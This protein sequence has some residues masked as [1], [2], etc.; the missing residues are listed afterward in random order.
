MQAVQSA[1]SV[2]PSMLVS[3]TYDSKLNLAVLKFYDPKSKRL[4]LW[5][6]NTG[7]KPYCYA[8]LSP[9][10]LGFLHDRD[11]VLDIRT[12][13]L[14]DLARD[15]SVDMS[16][17]TVADPLAIGGT[18]SDKSIRN[19]IETWESDIKYYE[20]YLYDK[21][22]VVGRYYRVENGNIT[23]HNMEI[24]DEVKLALKSLLWDKV[25]SRSM[26]DAEGF[27]EFISEWADLLNQPIPRIRRLAVDIEVE[28]EKD[29]IPDPKIAEKKITA[30][31][32]KGSDDFD[33][34]FVLRT[35]GT[36]E[37]TNDLADTVRVVFYDDEKEMIRDAFEVI[38]SFP[39]VITYN[40][41][42]FDL[43][44]LYHRAKRLGIGDEQNPV[45]MMRNSA[46]LKDGVHLDLYRTLSNRSFQ[47]YAFSQA[48]TDF[49]LNSVS[50]ALLGKEKIDYGLDFDQL[51]LY[52]TA[53]Y[54][55]NDSLLTY[56]LTS[57]NGDLLM[58]LLVIIARI[59]RM[60]VDDIARLGVSQWIRS[61]LY[62]EH[63]TRGCLIPNRAELEQRSKDVMSDAVI[64][65]KKYKG[66]LVVSPKEG[67]HFNVV[68]M[69]FAS[70]Y[71]SIIKVRN[72][73]YETVRCPHEECKKN[74]IPQTNHWTC[75]KRD[76]LT[77][78]IIGSLR[79]LRV[80]Y[81]K[82]LS[83]KKTL[84]DEQRQQY[85]VVSQALKVILN[86]SYG[87]MGAEI[88]P[89]YF[90][91]AAEATTAIGR[92]TIQQTINKCEAAGI[93]VL[94]GDT[95]SLFIKKPT[96]EQ[97]QVVIDQAKRDH[98][99]DLEIDKEYRYCVLSNRKKN[100]FGVTKSG[101]VDVKGLTGK[102]SHTPPFIKRLF[103]EILEVLA[104]I[105]TEGDFEEA[106]KEISGKIADYGRRVEAREIPLKDLTF[107]VML[108]KALSEYVKA[109]PQHIKAARQ[110]EDTRTIKRGDRIS[111]VK[112][113][114]RIGV[115]PIEKARM[116]EIDSKKYM[117]FME[118]TLEQITSSM[119]LDFDKILKKPKQS[120]LDEF[121][122]N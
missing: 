116:D 118:S 101:K 121:F 11:D 75:S 71:P 21:K 58:N 46:T 105:Q 99:V 14:H 49:S 87:V 81:Y 88:F 57:F 61:L 1:E 18:A 96:P 110:L 52:Q 106:K 38:D 47:I 67:I 89:L 10:E 117:E 115:K 76:G 37:G 43:P 56:Q 114:G 83:R 107:T 85:T 94:Y 5:K 113:I 108:S 4:F 33:K 31:G 78:M 91:P 120:G 13:Q 20:N 66:G 40:G 112:V 50:K 34:I 12:V 119:S 59:G 39:F 2:P 122:W 109:T 103:G 100:Y 9:D 93:N 69:D 28:A 51:T 97:I 6:D 104:R 27:K 48:Y 95:D 79:D 64:K 19:L 32:F 60:P 98:G 70:L 7:H 90:L 24:S 35:D 16:K 41:D 74:T 8:K 62:Y 29:R 86:A 55:Y 42:D 3:A 82:N 65:T 17:I 63:R 92:H 15:E 23:P 102:K 30:V 77:S 72:L 84:T 73:S 44:Y 22:L 80:N 111:Y 68:V 26:V 53:N 36:P 54:C 45:R 25:D